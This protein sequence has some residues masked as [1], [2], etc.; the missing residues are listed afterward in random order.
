MRVQVAR[1]DQS[2]RSQTAIKMPRTKD[3]TDCNSTTDSMDTSLSA[4]STKGR[5]KTALEKRRMVHLR[6]EHRRR[7]EI[8]AALNELEGELPE[9][10]QRRSRND[11]IVD[12]VN[13]IQQ[14]TLLLDSLLKEHQILMQQASAAET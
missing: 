5:P 14:L 6:C 13:Y 9:L 2:V 12:S 7:R 8:Q 11:T 4:V 3:D 10:Q 1:D